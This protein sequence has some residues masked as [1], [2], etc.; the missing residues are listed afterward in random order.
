MAT[1]SRRW[2]DPNAERRWTRAYTLQ[3]QLQ[4]QQPIQVLA[5]AAVV[6]FAT[7][8]QAAAPSAHLPL[9]PDP[10]VTPQDE[11]HSTVDGSPLDDDIHPGLLQV[12]MRD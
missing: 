7:P 2:P 11:E 5:P 9:L 8:I 12:E 1:R 3:Q 6:L 10:Q 4:Q